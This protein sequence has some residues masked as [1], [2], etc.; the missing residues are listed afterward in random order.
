MLTTVIIFNFYFIKTNTDSE[1]V[2]NPPT[3]VITEQDKFTEGNNSETKQLIWEISTKK[4]IDP[5]YVLGICMIETGGTLNTK[6][7]G[8]ETYCGRAKGIMQIVPVLQKDLGIQD[9]WNPR[10]NIEGGTTHLKYL[11]ELYSTLK[12]YDEDDN[13]MET[14]YV[15][16]IA[17]NWGQ[18]NVSRMLKKYNCIVISRLPYET[19]RYYRLIKSHCSGKDIG[20]EL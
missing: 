19:R 16:A 14:K 9:I 20:I 10:Q 13:I 8:V 4:G 17:Y 18:G 5:N 3:K 7:Q 2:Y 1:L 11:M 15:S 12:I 6:C